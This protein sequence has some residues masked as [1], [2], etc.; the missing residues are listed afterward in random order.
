MEP[1]YDRRRSQRKGTSK[2][3]SAAAT[4]EDSTRAR[5][6]GYRALVEAS[7]LAIWIV[8][9]SGLATDLC[10]WQALTGQTA[11]EVRGLGWLDAIHPDDRRRVARVWEKARRT[12][13]LYFATYR[14]RTADGGHR[15]FASRGVP[16]LDEDGNVREWIGTLHDVHE[17]KRAEEVLIF[18]GKASHVLVSSVDYH[19]TL[20]TVA[21]LTVPRLADYCRI[22]LIDEVSGEMRCEVVAYATP[23]STHTAHASPPAP[24]VLAPSDAVTAEAVRTRGPVLEENLGPAQ[25]ARIAPDAEQLRVVERLV[26]RTFLA[27]PLEARGRVIGAIGLAASEPGQYP[28]K[29]IPLIGELSHRIAMMIDNARL[30]EAER[31][32]RDAAK[33]ASRAKSDFLAVMSHELRTPLNAIIGYTDLVADGIVGP[34]NETQRE[35]L[36]RVRES[37]RHLIV[38]I[39]EVLS[40]SRIDAARQAPVLESVDLSAIAQ[41]TAAI[42]LPRAVAKGLRFEVLAADPCMVVTDGM[43]VRQIL[44][45][46]LSNAVKF[47]ARG[48]IALSVRRDG[49]LMLID[50][51]DTGGGIRPEHRERIFEPFW[52]AEQAPARRAGGIGLGLSVAR[53]LARALGGDVSVESVLAEGSRFT[54]SLPLAAPT[55]QRA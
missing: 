6:S 41:Q 16:V 46:L 50:V 39:D 30:Y 51:R 48:E 47:T 4:T 9:A 54:L 7:A 5:E 13:D 10:A 32:A 49:D 23:P 33:R 17:R 29:V 2:R 55:S 27:V 20:D 19:A 38:L 28:P 40:L 36:D 31:R 26:P 11:E 37:A 42:I 3:K 21:H 12:R 22:D 1:V 15:W 52:Q 24:R 18:L 43:K 25:Y 45:N 8:D 44:L 53:Q 35:Q 34:V 14:L